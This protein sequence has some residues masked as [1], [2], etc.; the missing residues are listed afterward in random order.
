MRTSEE[1]YH[2]V[3]WDARFD[4]ARFVIGIALRGDG[5]GRMPLTSFVPGG[6]IPWHRV[7]FFEADGEVVWDRSSGA[8][9]LGVTDAG[10]VR[11]PRRLRAPFFEA[12]TAYGTAGGG[13]SAA[14]G[15]AGPGVGTGSGGLRVLT[16]NTLWDRYDGDRIE[17]ARRRPLLLEALRAADADVIALQEVE[18]ELLRMLRAAD[19]VRD[20]YASVPGTREV[21]DYGLLLLSRLPVREA[22]HHVLGPHKAVTAMVV[23]SGGGPVTVA[24]THLTSDHCDDGPALREF[25][26]ARIA[27]AFAGVEGDLVVM[28]D[29]NDSGTGPQSVLGMRDAWLTSYGP[30]D[31][32]P[33]FDPGAN[34]L[35]AISSRTGNAGRLDRVLVRGGRQVA[36]AVLCGDS[37]AGDLFVS[38]HYGVRVDLAP[39]VDLVPGARPVAEVPRPSADP[40]DRERARELARRIADALTAGARPG[41]ASGDGVVHLAG[42]RRMGCELPGAD[43]DLVAALPGTADLGE[44]RT[45]LVRA[46][47]DARSVREV[48]GARVPGLRFSA[49]GLDVDLVVVGTGSVPPGAAV[50]R[51]SGLGEAAAVALGAVTDADAVRELAGPSRGKAFE[52]LAREVKAWARARGLD[53]APFGG[54][55]GLGWSVLAARTVREAEGAEGDELLRH[56]FGMWAAWDWR[57]A[58]GPDGVSRTGA[59]VTVMTPAEPVRSC[60]EQVGA[61]G[62]N[63]LVRELYHAWELLEAAAASGTGPWAGLLS[64]PPLSERH[65]DWAV[66]TVPPVMTDRVRGRMRALLT[67]LEAAGITGLHAWPRPFGDGPVRYAVGLGPGR[68]D[69]ALVSALAGEWAVGL[70]GTVV[71][72][73][74]PPGPSTPYGLLPS[75]SPGPPGA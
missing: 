30:G 39:G 56:F 15:G 71:T 63:L 19:W 4:P 55:P 44:V 65:T 14:A 28:G 32:T 60:T 27:E 67:A 75:D 43:L 17:T 25:Q 66:V 41:A 40:A 7:L 72:L 59:P 47:P 34:P 1:I 52:R 16:W 2:R 26:L 23:E 58:V 22:G 51:R 24:T 13:P 10:R 46:L 11:V 3:R 37:P 45:R 29:F 31:R 38:D 36:S 33:T 21:D 64:P 70:G 6:E 35:A 53:S 68:V 50:A 20:G 62:R 73:E 9:R 49:G 48:A 54:V 57:E 42:S 12:R 69:R 5:P 61:S 18:P 8:D 74:S